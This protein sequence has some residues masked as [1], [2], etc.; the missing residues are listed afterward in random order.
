MPA[1]KYGK[2][3]LLGFRASKG[4]LS[5]FPFSPEAVDAA[6]E[7]LAG[8]DLSKGTVRFTPEKPI[9]DAA[10]RQL[11]HHRLSEIEAG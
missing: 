4:H 8:F 1:F 3:S 5:V 6:R 10:L 11:V 9:P 7:A 2:R